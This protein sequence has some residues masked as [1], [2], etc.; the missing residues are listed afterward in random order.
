VRALVTSP[1]A[2][3]AARPAWRSVAVPDEHGGWGLTLE[4][5]L[6][7]LLVAPSAAG[8]ALGIAA[9]VAFLVRTPLKTVLVD[10]WRHR[11]LPRTRLALAV[12][13]GEVALLALL[14][15][16]ALAASGPSWLVPVA[17]AVPLVGVE[18]WFDMRSRS[19]RLAP[20]LAGAVGIAA[21][22][23]AIATAGGEGAR[24]AGALWLVVAARAVA[25]IPFVRVQIDR[26]RHGTGSLAVSDGAAVLGVAVAAAAVVL[27]D[28][29]AAGAAAVVALVVLQAWQVR[30][31]P[32]PA[33][34]LGLRQLFL[35]L[36]VVAVAAAGVA[37]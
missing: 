24:L 9:F 8:A 26:L 21:V 17:L 28:R 33:K 7:G 29:L 22:A 5:V 18:L 11:W 10:R 32:V 31:P 20:E 13:A 23:A 25:S 19:R 12:A 34:V 37:A 27:D 35:G 15:V 14:A 30:R 1:A 4:P 36:A 2:P 6:L 3:A 16:I